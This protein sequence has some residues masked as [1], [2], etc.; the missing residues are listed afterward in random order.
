M[1]EDY[2]RQGSR[3]GC[4]PVAPGLFAACLFL[5][6]RPWCTVPEENSPNS[7]EAKAS[8]YQTLETARQ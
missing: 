3:R 5:P 8:F 2:G 4:L 6:C 7:Q 1:S